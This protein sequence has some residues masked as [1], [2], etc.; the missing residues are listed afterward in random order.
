MTKPVHLDAKLL[1]AKLE[2]NE[3]KLPWDEV[4]VQY[5]PEEHRWIIN[6]ALKKI[7]ESA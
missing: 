1:L 5:T 2:N 6:Q 7:G 4:Y 3:G